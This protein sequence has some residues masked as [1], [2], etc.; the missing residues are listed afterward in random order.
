MRRPVKASSQA[1][2]REGSGRASS[3][4]LIFSGA[5]GVFSATGPPRGSLVWRAGLL[6]IS[7]CISAAANTVPNVVRI[8]FT[9]FH[10]NPLRSFPLRKP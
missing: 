1:S 3:N 9:V 6:G 7:P 10:D 5:M 8:C 2:D 4:C